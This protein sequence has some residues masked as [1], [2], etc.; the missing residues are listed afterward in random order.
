MSSLLVVFGWSKVLHVL[1]QY[2][3]SFPF[4]CLPED[5]LFKTHVRKGREK[6][7]NFICVVIL[8]YF[9]DCIVFWMFQLGHEKVA[10]FVKTLLA[11]Q[12]WKLIVS[13]LDFL[14][15]IYRKKLSLKAHLPHCNNWKLPKWL[16]I[17][18]LSDCSCM[19]LA[20]VQTFWRTFRSREALEF[21]I[22]VWLF[23][24]FGHIFLH[25]TYVCV[26]VWPTLQTM[27]QSVFN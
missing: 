18:W 11:L 12:I 22:Q 16:H 2:F 27:S 10:V 14:S 5:S 8:T 15:F 26:F 19:F 17:L 13:F 23:L 6:L 9:A 1:Q 21:S 20:H 3:Y 24:L 25:L 4:L 7:D